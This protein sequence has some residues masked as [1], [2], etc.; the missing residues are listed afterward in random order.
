MGRGWTLIN[1]I[2]RNGAWENNGRFRVSPNPYQLRENHCILPMVI[3][4]VVPGVELVLGSVVVLAVPVVVVTFVVGAIVVVVPRAIVVR[5]VA[6][7]SQCWV[8]DG[9]R[10]CSD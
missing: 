2:K 7:V 8:D 6:V 1:G 5:I 3:V 10:N 4:V 9:S